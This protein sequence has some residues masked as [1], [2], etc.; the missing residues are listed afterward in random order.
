MTNTPPTKTRTIAISEGFSGGPL[1]TR[2]FRRALSAAGFKVIKDIKKADIIFAHSAACYGVPSRVSAQLVIF[3]GPPYWPGRPIGKRLVKTYKV[4]KKHDVANFGR[5]YYLKK[6]V[7][8][9]AYVILR[10]RLL[11]WGLIKNRSLDF[12]KLN[13]GKIVLVRNTEDTYCS[14]QIKDD[15][16]ESI[17]YVELPGVHDDYVTN[18]EPYIKLIQS[19]YE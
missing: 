13:A 6:K 4:L 19:E 8:G 12:L 5:L 9:L 18:P 14:P 7:L 11:W 16:S 1:L 3:V 15:L 2:A 17:K 10:P